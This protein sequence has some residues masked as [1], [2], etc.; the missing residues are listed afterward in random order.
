MC[1]RTKMYPLSLFGEKKSKM[2]CLESHLGECAAALLWVRM[3]LAKD[4]EMMEVRTTG[5]TSFRQLTGSF[6]GPLEQRRLTWGR[7]GPMLTGLRMLSVPF[8]LVLSGPVAF[9]A[10]TLDAAAVG[11]G[12]RSFRQSRVVLALCYSGVRCWWRR[13]S[14]CRCLCSQRWLWSPAWSCYWSAP[15][16]PV[17]IYALPLWCI[18]S[19]TSVPLFKPAGHLTWR[20]H[21]VL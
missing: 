15:H 2:D 1:L 3:S 11:W 7:S 20:P 5:L 14:Q 9:L 8:Q 12:R 17:G 18:S 6:F 16:C 10:L 13:L 21:H 19:W 4:F